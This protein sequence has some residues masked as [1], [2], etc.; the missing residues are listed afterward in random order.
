MSGPVGVGVIGAGVISTQYLENLTRAADVDVVMVA[1]LDTARAAD[2]AA[3]YGVPRGGSVEE[4]LARDDIEI[5]VNLTI[6]AAHVPVGRD[7]IAAGKHV[8]SEKPLALDLPSGRELVEAGAA[9]GLRVACA[10]DTILGQGLQT[11]FRMLADGDIGTPLT[12]ITQFQ[13]PGP[14][15]W[16]P[17]PEFLYAVG[18]G[19]L[20][21]IGPYYLSTLVQALGPATRVI[22]RGSQS[23]AERVIGSGPKAGTV[24]PVEV[25]THVAGIIDFAS[26]AS[27]Q[28]LF[29]F[30]SALSRVGVVEVA[31][32]D[33]T[34]AFPDPN[35]FDGEVSLWRRGEDDV[36]RVILPE[37]PFT[38]G[39]GVVELA[40]AIREG[41]PERCSGEFALHIL[42]LMASLETSARTGSAVELTTSPV[43]APPLPADWDPL[44]RT[45]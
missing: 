33:G 15:S 28:V 22:A 31:G 7:V 32:T 30:Q 25:P 4:L 23:H 20:F 12:A 40:R 8:F 5:V 17:S 37:A 14:E 9:A 44:A 29:S 27:A 2:R 39:S 13:V 21:D 18:G 34:I 36:E 6:P 16:H 35:M 24:F 1:D 41:R 3:E 45:L 19:P 38:R 11:G 26:G 10:P 43:V 42:D